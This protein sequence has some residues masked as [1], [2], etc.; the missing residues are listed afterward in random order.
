MCLKKPHGQER[1]LGNIWLI[2]G[3]KVKG[4]GNSG[5]ECSVNSSIVRGE[6]GKISA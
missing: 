5:V 2:C 4:V 6:W 3:M 1:E